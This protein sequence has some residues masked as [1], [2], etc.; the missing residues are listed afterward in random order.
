[1]QKKQN[2]TQK[3]LARQLQIA[4]STLSY[5]EMGKRVRYVY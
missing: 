5:W 1:M 2:M 4:G 3:E